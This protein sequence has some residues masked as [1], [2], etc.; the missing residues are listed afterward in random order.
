MLNVFECVVVLV[1][2]PVKQSAHYWVA[3]PGISAVIVLLTE[4]W[5]NDIGPYSEFTIKRM[6]NHV[7]F[8]EP[9]ILAKQ[10]PGV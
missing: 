3:A 9:R 7:D 6:E 10:I 5:G 8:G 4:D 2:T 1:D